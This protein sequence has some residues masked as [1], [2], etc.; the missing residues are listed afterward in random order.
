VAVGVAR[1]RPAP[2]RAVTLPSW[3]ATQPRA[4]RRRAIAAISSRSARSDGMD[5]VHDA[6]DDRA[7]RQ[8]LLLQ[9][10][11]D[12]V[13]LRHDEHRGA[14]AGLDQVDGD[15]RGAGVVLLL[16]ERLHDHELVADVGRVL[17]GRDDVAGD[18]AELHVFTWS[19][20][21]TMAASTGTK[22]SSSASAASREPTR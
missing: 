16:V 13:A 22:V 11:P 18:A 8:L 5:G 6:D 9:D 4:W 10:L 21:P 3:F 12:A 19:T 20:M 15:E 2:R 17:H 7:D 1:N 14:G